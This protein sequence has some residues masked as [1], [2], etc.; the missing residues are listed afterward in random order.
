M[1]IFRKATHPFNK[2]GVFLAVGI[3]FL[4][5]IWINLALQTVKCV[6]SKQNQMFIYTRAVVQTHP[7]YAPQKTVFT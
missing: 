4:N 1:I 7:L 6:I 2:E 3:R 5:V